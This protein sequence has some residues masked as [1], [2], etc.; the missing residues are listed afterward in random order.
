M[1]TGPTSGD[2]YL[3]DD[4][5]SGH[6]NSSR[7]IL[8]EEAEGFVNEIVEEAGGRYGERAVE[9]GGYIAKLFSD[10]IPDEAKL[11][12]GK[13]DLLTQDDKLRKKITSL[14]QR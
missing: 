14:L 13:A 4:Y 11:S 5:Q 6:Y 8:D 7:F 2:D 10:R 9:I 3:G 1:E 12:L